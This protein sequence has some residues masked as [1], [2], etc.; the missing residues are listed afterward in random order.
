MVRTRQQKGHGKLVE[1]CKHWVELP[2]EL[3]SRVMKL[4]WEKLSQRT[5]RRQLT[6][7]YQERLRQ[8]SEEHEERCQQLPATQL[9]AT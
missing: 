7:D 9:P 4:A 5:E 2:Q 8:I 3:R 6:A 1:L